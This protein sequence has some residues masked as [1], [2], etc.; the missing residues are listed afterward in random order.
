[1]DGDG[2]GRK[3]GFYISLVSALCAHL[4]HNRNNNKK[5]TKI[6]IRLICQEIKK[7]D[8]FTDPYGTRRAAQD[9]VFVDILMSRRGDLDVGVVREFV[10]EYESSTKSG[11]HPRRSR[12]ERS[13]ASLGNKFP[14]RQSMFPADGVVKRRKRPRS[15]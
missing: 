15:T 14:S 13:A 2:R 7:R 1:V 3:A 9:K 8:I 11:F 4:A 6:D 12:T 5:L 10:S